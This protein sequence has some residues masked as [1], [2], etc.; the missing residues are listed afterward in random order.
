MSKARDLANAGTALTTVSATELGYLDGVTSA[1]QTQID[2]KITGSSAIAPTIVDAK[3][4]I[5]AASASDTVARLAVGANDT[6]L[7][8]DSS[9]ATGLKWAAVAGGY[10]T[11][12]VFTSSGTWTV[13]T[14]ITKCAY[15]VVGGG[16]GGG[17]G[18]A[19]VSAPALP[20]DGGTGGNGSK[21]GYDPFYTVVPG[22]TLT[23][24][25]GGGGAGGA[26]N[27][28][29]GTNTNTTSGSAGTASLFDINSSDTTTSALIQK[30]GSIGAINGASVTSRVLKN[31]FNQ[32]GKLSSNGLAATA[33]TTLGTGGTSTLA[34]FMTGGG[35]GQTPN[36]TSTFTGAAGGSGAGGGGN[37][38]AGAASATN[39]TTT[40]GAGS[41]GAANSGS[42]GGGGGGAVKI[43]TTTTTI[44][45]GAGGA[46]GSGIVVIFY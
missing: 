9:T 39:I 27:I 28:N 21:L 1:V 42:G 29:T 22:E 20:A 34:G 6:V 25:I 10:S 11:Y 14:G 36:T 3:G 31:L 16:D 23:V 37:G 32:T 2:S 24:T 7:T 15:Y 45:S 30:T 26:A 46:G 5:I 43:G 33:G 41:P 40:A 4:D 19:K 44:T 17:G 35:G 8:A 18:A 13:P 38:G 12:E